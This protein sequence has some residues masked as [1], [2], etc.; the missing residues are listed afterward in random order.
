MPERIQY[1]ELG[2]WSICLVALVDPQLI[3]LFYGK[4][5]KGSALKLVRVLQQDI[6]V[7]Y[8]T[9]KSWNLPQ[10]LPALDNVRIGRRYLGYDVC[11]MRC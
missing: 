1:F 10:K 9:V 2:H 11:E 7:E 6:L 4:Y 5:I 8:D 3:L